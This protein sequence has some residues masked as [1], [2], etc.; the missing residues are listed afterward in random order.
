MWISTSGTEICGSSSRGRLIKAMRPTASAARM[1]NGVRGEVINPF[2]SHPAS[3]S[4]RS[5]SPCSLIAGHHDV[6]SVQAG[7]DSHH[8]H[9][10]TI[11]RG[12]DDNTA[13]QGFATL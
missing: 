3:P 12:A 13:H 5:V 7:Q 9:T 4:G 8:R 10:V 11:M 6:T 2:V 1:I